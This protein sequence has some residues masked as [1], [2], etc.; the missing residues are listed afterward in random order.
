MSA[1]ILVVDNVLNLKLLEARLSAEYF[2]VQTA[3][4]GEETLII[5]AAGKCD[6]VLLDVMMP[7]MDGFEVCRRLKSDPTTTHIPVVMV[8]ALDHPRDRVRGLE[9]GADNFLTK[10]VDEV[11][12]IARVRSLSRLKLVMDELRA[13]ALTSAALGVSDMIAEPW[14]AEA[15]AGRI[16]LI[17]NRPRSCERIF[18]TLAGNHDVCPKATR[19]RRCFGRLRAN[20]IW[21]SSRSS[22]KITMACAYVANC[23]RWSVPVKYPSWPSPTP[24]TSRESCAASIWV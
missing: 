16:I 20:L 1:R 13:R 9:C 23:A 19:R 14:G 6:V 12:L 24:T 15:I 21:R 5:C 10:P 22:L 18:D 2:E 8:T 3:T 7:G 4:T 11:A 17:D